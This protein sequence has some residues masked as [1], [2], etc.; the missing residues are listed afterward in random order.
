[1]EEL[2]S[3]FINFA[4]NNDNLNF[5]VAWILA[6]RMQIKEEII[7]KIS[8]NESYD[9]LENISNNMLIFT[10][11]ILEDYGAFPINDNGDVFR[12]ENN[13][14]CMIEFYYQG[15]DDSEIIRKEFQNDVAINIDSID[16]IYSDYK[17]IINFL[18][19]YKDSFRDIMS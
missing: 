1:M 9:D 8:N 4:K 7:D 3:Q 19:T 15:P 13:D 14:N 2:K 10:S 11:S 17:E 6:N 12:T 16:I 18:K 5:I